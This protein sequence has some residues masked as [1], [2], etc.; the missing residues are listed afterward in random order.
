MGDAERGELRVR[1]RAFDHGRP[2]A[3]ADELL[4]VGLDG[5]REPPDLGAEAGVRDQ[6]DRLLVVG[7]DAREAGFDPVDARLV[8]RLRDRELVLRR[9]DDADGLL[10]VAQRRVVE[11]DGVVRLRL[12]REPVEIARPD[13]VAVDGH[14][15][16]IPS[17][18]LQSFSGSPSVTRKLSSTRRPPPSGQY[19]PGSIASTIPASIVP[20]PAWCA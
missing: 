3:E 16:T 17:G 14:A 9:E 5:A 12:E 6:P 8:E 15:R 11:A 18:K 4:D 1:D 7:G 13:L 20:P 2:D 10:A 19:T